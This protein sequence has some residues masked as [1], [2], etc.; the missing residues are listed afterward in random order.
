ML[1]LKLF[2]IYNAISFVIVENCVASANAN[3]LTNEAI[4]TFCI[5][6]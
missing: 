2:L 1:I 4:S 6:F 3:A 5:I